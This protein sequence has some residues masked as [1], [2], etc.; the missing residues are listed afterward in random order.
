MKRFEE[1]AVFVM[2]GEIDIPRRLEFLPSSVDV[3]CESRGE[4]RV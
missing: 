4:E 3:T 2:K 1:K